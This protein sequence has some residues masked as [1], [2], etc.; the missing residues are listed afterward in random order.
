MRVQEYTSAALK[1]LLEK[2]KVCTFEELM[3][4]LGTN[5]RVTVFRKLAELPYL[6]SYSHRGSYYT[7]KPLCDFDQRGLWSFR[8]A[9]FSAF[10][11]LL[12]TGKEFVRQSDSGYSV[13]ELDMILH[14]DTQQ[15]L[16]LLYKKSLVSRA[17]YNGVFVYFSVNEREKKLQMAAR[18]EEANANSG[19]ASQELLA[20]ELKASIILF[21]SLLD[22][23]QRRFYA[24]LES[25]KLGKGGDATVASLLGIDPHTVSRGRVELMQR[26]IKLDR[27]RKTGAGR[28]SVEKKLRK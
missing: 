19:P 7:L 6:T 23:Q 20:H 21:F 18:R 5:V 25:M 9:C 26:D 22:E 11:T 13:S 1:L 27:I 12:E 10:G 17:K 16:S 2:K 15:A 28:K 3:V 8:E 4:A 14:V 24:G